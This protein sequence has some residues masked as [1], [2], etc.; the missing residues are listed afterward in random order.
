MVLAVCFWCGTI[1]LMLGL[2]A[3]FIDVLLEPELSRWVKTG[4][5]SFIL[6]IAVAFNWGIVL[7]SAPLKVSSYWD[8][9]YSTAGIEADGIRWNLYMSRLV[10]FVENRTARDY[11]D[12]D[13]S[14]ITDEGVAAINQTSFVPC[15]RISTNQYSESDTQGNVFAHLLDVGP[16][17]FRCDKLPRQTTMKFVVALLNVDTVANIFAHLPKPG[18]PLFGP[19]RKPR[20]LC[21]NATYSV[22]YRPYTRRFCVKVGG[23]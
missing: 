23:G 16:Q 18:T 12:L 17:R 14:L 6:A 5:A 22:N 9:G 15:E 4:I 7:F 8:N 13:L 10:V 3:S 11:T 19:K 21:V 2:L 20:S 1:L